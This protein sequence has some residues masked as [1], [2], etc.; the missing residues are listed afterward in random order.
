MAMYRIEPSSH[1]TA[2]NCFIV[3][4]QQSS[5]KEANDYEGR[6]TVGENMQDPGLT[7]PWSLGTGSYR[8]IASVKEGFAMCKEAV[9]VA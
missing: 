6:D 8:T 2:W 4:F 3:S 1:T 9:L 5:S 7:R